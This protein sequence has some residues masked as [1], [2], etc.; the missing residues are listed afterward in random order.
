MVR[1][2]NVARLTVAALLAWGAYWAAL[3]WIDCVRQ[4]PT[5]DV[6]RACTLG[7]GIPGFTP[8]LGWNVMVGAVCLAAALWVVARR[9][10]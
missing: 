5:V 3:P 10:P 9:Q 7:V 1:G 6:L 4:F 8:P 2:W